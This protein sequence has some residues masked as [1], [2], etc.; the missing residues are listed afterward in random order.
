MIKEILNFE[1]NYLN[2]ELIIKNYLLE[3]GFGETLQAYENE[4]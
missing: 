2:I 4:T 3:N 1:I